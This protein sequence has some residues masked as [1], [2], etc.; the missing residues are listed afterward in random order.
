MSSRVQVIIDDEEREAFR[1]RAASEGLSLSAWLRDAGR[2]RLAEHRPSP[3]DSPQTL[4]AFFADLPD[5]DTGQEPDWEQ[6]LAV[7]AASR[8][9][10]TGGA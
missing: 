3:L 9:E 10:G 5:T 2:R 8:A 7:I 1:R 4:R 6:H